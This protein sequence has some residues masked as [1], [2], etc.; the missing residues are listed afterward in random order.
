[1]A[2]MEYEIAMLW[3]EGPLSYVEQLCAVSYL[4]VGQHV[5]LYHYGEISNVPEGIEVVDG[6]TV[7]SMKSFLQHGRTGS[8]ALFSDVFRYHLL[9]KKDRVIWADTDAYCLRPFTSKTGHFYGWESANHINGGVLSLPRD[10]EALG[11]LLEMTRD[12]YGVP[13]WYTPKEQMRL[14]TLKN[15]GRP[16]HVSELDWGVWG[17][18]AITH[19]LH[20]TGEARHALPVHMLYPMGFADRRKMMRTGGFSK[21]QRMIK[22]D[23]FSIHFYGRRMKRFLANHGGKPEPGSYLHHLIRKH[24]IDMTA[25]PVPN[26]PPPASVKSYVRKAVAGTGTIWKSL[27]PRPARRNVRKSP[28]AE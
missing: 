2:K 21:I 14:Q 23:S 9:T 18:H 11:Q 3:V 26:I 5:K 27:A 25:A 15:A 24:R 20:K 19:Y 6:N 8:F 1:M 10:S 4:A 12:E 7:L 16:R 17:P 28:A 22:K 13:E